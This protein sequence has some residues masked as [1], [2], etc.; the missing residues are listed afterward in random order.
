[1]RLTVFGGTGP[2]GMLLVQQAPVAGHDVTAYAR[3]PPSSP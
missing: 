1:M 2:T 3:N